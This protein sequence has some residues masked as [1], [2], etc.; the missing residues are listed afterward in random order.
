LAT[1]VFFALENKGRIV[2]IAR[3]RCPEV[4]RLVA[5]AALDEVRVAADGAEADEVVRAL[6]RQEADRLEK[7]LTVLGLT[8][9]AGFDLE[10][11]GAG[12]RNGKWSKIPYAHATSE[13]QRRAA[14]AGNALV[15][16]NA[17]SAR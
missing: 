14:E 13:A 9:G 16:Q 4:V 11:C 6:L 7:A 12:A 5:K 8:P 1:L 2:P 17:V 10:E 3:S 15:R